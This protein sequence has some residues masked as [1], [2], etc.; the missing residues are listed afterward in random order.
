MM[1]SNVVAAGFIVFRSISCQIHYLLLQA[2][3]G[4]HHWTPPKGTGI[5]VTV[6][7]RSSVPDARK[8]R[9]NTEFW[10]A[11]RLL[12]AKILLNWQTG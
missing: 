7:G 4:I 12:D 5:S 11:W 8:S 3:D 6:S 1:S 10:H 2:S 9:R